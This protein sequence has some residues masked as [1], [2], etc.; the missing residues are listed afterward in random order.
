MHNT[1]PLTCAV[2]ARLAASLG[3][4]DWR[5]HSSL[6]LRLDVEASPFARQFT[7]P[8]VSRGRPN[9]AS[10]CIKYVPKP[11]IWVEHLRDGVGRVHIAAPKRRSSTHGGLSGWHVGK[12]PAKRQKKETELSSDPLSAQGYYYGP[13]SA[14][15][16]FP[17][18][19]A[20]CVRHNSEDHISEKQSPRRTI[21]RQR[22]TR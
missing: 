7:K 19:R 20:Q 21:F 9:F 16:S 8:T 10:R 11:H 1:P 6:A 2:V 4:G 13:V 5:V 22:L 14:V 18:Q 3:A 17:D 15:V 12:L